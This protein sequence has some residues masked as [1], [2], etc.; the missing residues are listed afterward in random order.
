[1]RKAVS[2]SLHSHIYGA[3]AFFRLTQTK[4]QRCYLLCQKPISIPLGAE[5]GSFREPASRESSKQMHVYCLQFAKKKKN[6]EKKYIHK[7]INKIN[8][9]KG[10]VCWYVCWYEQLCEKV[11]WL[12]PHLLNAFRPYSTAQVLFVFLFF[13]YKMAVDSAALI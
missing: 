8:Q 4:T 10:L 9:W 7:L 11:V 1:M 2:H 3:P 5:I 13:F 12:L 6:C